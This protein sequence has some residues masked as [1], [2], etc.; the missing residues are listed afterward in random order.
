MN[1]ASSRSSPKPSGTSPGQI[2]TL[3]IAKRWTWKGDDY[4]SGRIENPRIEIEKLGLIALPLSGG[5]LVDLREI[6]EPFRRPDPYAPLWRKL[7]ATSRPDFRMDPIAWGQFPGAGEE[8]NPTCDAAELA[9]AGDYIG[10]RDLLM[11]TLGTDLRCLDAHAH[12]GNHKF[13]DSPERAIVHYEIGIRI[14]EL[15][16]PPDFHG[17]LRWSHIYNRPFRRCLHGYGLCLWRLGQLQHARQVFER[18]LSLNPNDNQ[19][20]R[21]CWDDV[22]NGRSW[23]EMQALEDCT[24]S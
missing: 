8:D 5:D 24:V 2:V 18:I 19:G 23:E 20:A 6:S 9:E 4:A 22:R 1:P 11:E 21:F 10:A 14:G 7:T 3:I 12:L 16:F 15:S 17:L 13:D